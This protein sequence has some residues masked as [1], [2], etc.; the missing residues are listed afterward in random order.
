MDVRIEF[1]ECEKEYYFDLPTYNQIVSKF[2]KIE[3]K[4]SDTDYQGSSF[5]LLSNQNKFGY[6]SISW[7]SCSGCDA[8]QACSDYTDLQNLLDR[9]EN[10]VIWFDNWDEIKE[11][12]NARD[13][14]TTVD[15]HTGAREF[16]IKFK[17]YPVRMF[18]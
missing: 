7:G 13:W 3:I 16:L 18:K 2:G 9:L 8:L 15:W 11:W 1:S 5:Y 6:L 14:E 12:V 17:E 10:Q 4:S